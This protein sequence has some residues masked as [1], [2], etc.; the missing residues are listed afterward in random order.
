MLLVLCQDS[1]LEVR[2]AGFWEQLR[3]SVAA[4]NAAS[5]QM[6]ERRNAIMSH[7]GQASDRDRLAEAQYL[8]NSRGLLGM[9]MQGASAVYGT[10]SEGQWRQ[11]DNLWRKELQEQE[12]RLSMLKMAQEQ[13]YKEN[14]MELAH[15][16]DVAINK[17]NQ[18]NALSQIYAKGNVDVSTDA[19]IRN[20]AFKQETEADKYWNSLGMT[21]TYS[22]SSIND[23]APVARAI[24]GSGRK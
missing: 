17:L 20:N 14:N 6:F 7:I 2:V 12:H 16:Y 18:A 10:E 8:D 22:R 3:E 9:A 15:K 23:M 11:D 1:C 21:P 24:L 5:N 19:R 13:A 4:N